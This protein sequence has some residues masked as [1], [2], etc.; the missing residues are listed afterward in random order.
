MWRAY[1]EKTKDAL[2]KSAKVLAAFQRRGKECKGAASGEVSRACEQADTALAAAVV[3][4]IR[5]G[6]A[7]PTPDRR[8]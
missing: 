3:A 6:V 8:P 4:E 5:G 2:L 7:I 1:S